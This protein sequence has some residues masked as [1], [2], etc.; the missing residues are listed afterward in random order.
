[1]VPI[2]GICNTDNV[3]KTLQLLMDQIQN[4]PTTNAH[5]A[6]NRYNYTQIGNKRTV[7]ATYACEE[8]L[9]NIG[10]PPPL[11]YHNAWRSLHRSNKNTTKTLKARRLLGCD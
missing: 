5:H 8:L 1:M 2:R 6:Y 11:L 10:V 3:L 9:M 7:A 4:T